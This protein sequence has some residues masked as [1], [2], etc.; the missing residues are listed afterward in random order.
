MRR[1]QQ[2]R[3][4]PTRRS[5]GEEEEEEGSTKR[6][7][8]RQ[9][10]GEG[11]DEDEDEEEGAEGE[12]VREE[13]WQRDAI[14]AHLEECVHVIGQLGVAACVSTPLWQSPPNGK[15]RGPASS[16]RA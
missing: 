2:R 9:R 11:E 7:K 8:I 14:P 6:K 5:G 10:G 3:K 16:E 15:R 12:S 4:T 1:R 13:R